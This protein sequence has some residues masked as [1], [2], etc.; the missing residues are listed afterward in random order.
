MIEEL[1]EILR[2]NHVT[3]EGIA[4]V[5]QAYEFAKEHHEGQLRRSGEP[6]IMH[7]VNVAIILA[8]M[9]MDVPTIIAG[10]LHDTI[11]DTDITYE[12]VRDLFGEEIADLVD[13]VTKLKNLNYKTKQENQAE[14]IR[15]MVLAMAQ[16][17]RVVIVKFA[18]RLHNMRTLEYM[19]DQKRMEKATETIE[20]YA[21]LAD[22]LGISRIKWELED[23]SLRYLDTDGYK[24]LTEMVKRRREEREELIERQIQEISKSLKQAGIKAEISGRPK[25]FYS[26]YKKMMKKGKTFDEIY[27]LSA[28]RIM[29]D[30]VKDCYGALGVI[31]MLYK[32]IPGRFKDYISMP[33]P[34]KYQSL[35][36][37]VINQD[38]ETFE[39]QIRTYAM[40]RTAEYGIAAHWKYK[41]GVS[42]STSF[43]ENLTWLRQLLEWQKDLKDPNDFMNTLK[44][45]FFADEVFVFTPKGDVINLPDGSTP[46]D[47]A[48]RVHT[49][50]GNTCVG[51][52]VNGRIVP[53][54]YHLE[55]GNI[56]E[57][58]TNKNSS[59]S[60]DWLNIVQSPQA[61]TKI[62]QYFK[63]KDREK[64]ILRGR[65]LI[66]QEGKKL[67]YPASSFMRE[68]WMEELRK[69]FKV[70]SVDDIYA[71]VGYGSM[72]VNQV[73]V[74]LKDNIRK[75][76]KK[77]QKITP[78]NA[79]LLTKER[80]LHKKTGGII[81][82]GID[83]VKVH[84]A[85]CCN[86]VPGDD[87]VGFITMGR[88]ISVHRVDCPNLRNN[89]DE[90]RLISVMWDDDDSGTYIAEIEIKAQNKN[91]AF[92]DI[93]NKIN[94]QKVSI[95][96]LSAKNHDNNEMTVRIS[97]EIHDRQELKNILNA[98]K[99]M[100]E[101]YDVYR[102]NA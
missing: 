32:P 17:I 88:G 21:P 2:K 22:R 93:A 48:Y 85:K 70:S 15:K 26:I 57:V 49:Q 50:V 24:R 83:N 44:V 97:M 42:K 35:H 36:T 13:G 84:T 41:E 74:K 18:D 65:D 54:N 51:A 33:K 58:I 37:T 9:N 34:N 25:N 101:V 78:Q 102:I 67:G 12:D 6:Y 90:Q 92:T 86:P 66:E 79:S 43:D 89:L 30:T 68:E 59:P 91:T 7:P 64:N 98:I 56:V 19:N 95:T 4:L 80:S 38:G 46:I 73:A 23:L 60:L 40:H 71:M 29:V 53:L 10:L 100:P 69:R 39:V 55:N 94:D 47:F 8:R 14:N 1:L 61:K 96:N 16:D 75:E 20:I 52:K 72:T 27:D 87:I 5:V 63:V 62:R 99:K 28:I 3:E 31:H 11:E 82:R 45:D 81:V 76:E 77:N